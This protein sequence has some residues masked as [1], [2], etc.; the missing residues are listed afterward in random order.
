[1][2]SSVTRGVV[3]SVAAFVLCAVALTG[4]WEEGPCRSALAAGR[5]YHVSL[6][7]KTAT[8]PHDSPSNTDTPSCAGVDNLA[9]SGGIDVAIPRNPAHAEFGQGECWVSA[10]DVASDIGLLLGPPARET[11][12]GIDY[13]SGPIVEVSG[14]ISTGGCTGSWAFTVVDDPGDAYNHVSP[15]RWAGRYVMLDG[16]NP[17]CQT[18]YPAVSESRCYDEWDV[19]VQ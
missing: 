5:T 13:G 11:L 3:G 15:H 12:I 19:E 4:C 8:E 16:T 2:K 14:T 9:A 17:A 1:M 6:Q 10:G 7:A 18:A